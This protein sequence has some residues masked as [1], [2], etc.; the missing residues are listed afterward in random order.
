LDSSFNSTGKVTTPI[1]SGD[2]V[3]FALALQG[4]GKILVAGYAQPT[5][6]NE[7]FALVRYNGNG[8]LDTSFNGTGKVVTAFS[9]GGDGGRSVAVRSDGKIIVAGYAYVG[10]NYDFALARYNSDGSL[11][12]SFN[13]TGKLT[14]AIQ[15]GLWDVAKSVVLQSDGKIVVA[16]DNSAGS[17]SNFAVVRYLGDAA[18]IAVEQPPGAN[19]MD[20]SA[21]VAFGAVLVGSTVSRTFT[22][23]NTGNADLIGLGI[24]FDGAAAA[25][26]T[27]T[28][29]PTAPVPGPSG[30]T[31]FTVRFAPTVAGVK[32]ATLHLASNDSDENPFDIALTG[33]ALAPNADDDGDGVTNAAEVN[34]ASVG[35][36]PIVDSTTLITLLRNNGLFRAADMQNLAIG[37]PLLMRD[38]GTGHFHLSIGVER[39]PNLT[40][41]LPLTGF[42]PTYDVLTGRID[43]E[44]LPDA[45]NAQFYRV[46]GSKP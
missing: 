21:N 19:L 29:N 35:F 27:V 17:S 11:D 3:G 31:M 2:D 39:S 37:S 12:A 33:R 23:K 44:F 8:S 1:S 25:D 5:G 40:G 20:G 46:F 32:T 30:S 18:E 13:G 4:D 38:P 43:L 14:T 10:S 41:W 36:D 22:I 6:S 24:T 34:L 42:T 28:A 7:D 15:S 9:I 16:G 26:F 45:S